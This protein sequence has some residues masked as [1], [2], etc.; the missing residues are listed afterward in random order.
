MSVMSL[1]RRCQRLHPLIAKNAV[2]PQFASISFVQIRNGGGGREFS[3]DAGIV[4]GE[5]ARE[6][7]SNRD[8]PEWFLFMLAIKQEELTKIDDI[9]VHI[10]AG[11][12]GIR[13]ITIS[14][15][16]ES[17]PLLSNTGM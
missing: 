4:H 11:K 10:L 15:S 13:I 3:P 2:K 16:M 12:M 17:K 5:R 9:S 14:L 6:M 7:G 8:E 1:F